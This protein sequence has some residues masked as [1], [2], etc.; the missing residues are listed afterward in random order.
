MLRRFQKTGF[1]AF[2]FL[3]CSIMA[4]TTG[5]VS[6]G[7]KLTRQYAGFVNR[8]H[9]VLRVVLYIL[10]SV[11]FVATLLIDAI[12]YNTMDFWEGRVS[13]GTYEFSEDGKL[14][15][16]RH[17]ISP[18][19]SL[20]RSVIHV[21]GKDRAVLQTV[22]LQETPNHEIEVSIDGKVRTRVK[23]L[24]SIPV[25]TIFDDKGKIVKTELIVSDKRAVATNH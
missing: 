10:T 17:E 15:Q 25:A 20:K 9:I 12:V 24:E 16:A 8:Q 11:V 5:C 2:S 6:G 22:V 7:F 19:T 23:N 18:E 4:F 3:A 1:Y 14:Y 13:Q 21:L